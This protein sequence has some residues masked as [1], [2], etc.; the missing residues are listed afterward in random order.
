MSK[1]TTMPDFE[2]FINAFLIQSHQDKGCKILSNKTYTI[3]NSE[4]EVT[5]FFKPVWNND[6]DVFTDNVI[7]QLFEPGGFR[8]IC[9]DTWGECVDHSLISLLLLIPF[10]N[11]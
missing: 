9:N 2:K 1:V 10:D 4:N 7:S 11:S 3:V 5:D 6:F 8:I